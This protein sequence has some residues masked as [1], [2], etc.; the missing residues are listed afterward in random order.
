MRNL[1]ASVAAGLFLIGFGSCQKEDLTPSVKDPAAVFEVAM[2]GHMQTRSIGDGKTATELLYGVYAVDA[3]DADGNPTSFT[4]V[5][6]GKGVMTE[7]LNFRVE[8][9]LV[10]NVDYRIV[11]WAQAPGNKAYAVDFAGSATVT[12]DYTTAANDETR[13]AFYNFQDVRMAAPGDPIPVLLYRPLAQINFGSSKE[14]FEAIRH[15]LSK[16]LTSAVTFADAVVPDV[17]SLTSGKITD[18]RAKVAFTSSAAPCGKGAGEPL[19]VKDGTTD[20][21]YAY[22]SVNYIFADTA[23]DMMEKPMKASFTHDKGTIDLMIENLP[24]QANYR[25][26]IL[27]NLFTE[28]AVLAIE[29]EPIPVGDHNESYPQQDDD[30]NSGAENG[31]GNGTEN[32]A[33]KE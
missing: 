20:V 12:A 33:E 21:S 23:K 3:K 4:Y 32:D 9:R 30:N 6:D 19:V 8:V 17:F 18:S 22:A 2:P 11:F 29:I 1:L 25:T 7:D 14:D 16:D 28:Q 26:N 15:F 27:G 13:D 10:R 31:T 24:Y 5:Q